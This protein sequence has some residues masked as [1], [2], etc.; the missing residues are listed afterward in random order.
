VIKTIDS[1]IRLVDSIKVDIY[2]KNVKIYNINID[3]YENKINQNEEY[4]ED[5]NT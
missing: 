4:N 1:K 2:E 5:Y 3:E